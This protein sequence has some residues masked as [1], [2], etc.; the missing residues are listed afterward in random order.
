M[1]DPTIYALKVD[2]SWANVVFNSLR[3][4]VGKFGWS[5][6]RDDKGRELSSADLQTLKAKIEALGWNNLTADEAD[7]YQSFLL[8][9]RPGDWVVY[10]NVP[11]WGLCTVARVTAP[12]F[13][14]GKGED[15]NH[16][17]GVDPNSVQDFDRNH[18]IVHPALSARLKLQGR[19]WRIYA[20]KEFD[21]LWAALR[22][23]TTS[24]PRTP[25]TNAILLGHEM[26]PLLKQITE[27]VQRTHP[28]Y[29]LEALLELVFKV[30]PGVRSVIRQGGAGD[31]GADLIV[32][33]EGGLPH[34]ALQVQQKWVVQAKSYVG[35]HWDTRAVKDISRAFDRHPDADFGLIVS[36][37]ASSSP[38]LDQA[39]S[40][41]EKTSGK[42]VR[43]MIGSELAKFIL[44][45]GTSVLA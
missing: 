40:Q 30:V 35:E 11:Q 44:K 20:A 15:F 18:D 12:Y 6:M 31:H 10:I 19:K 14:D 43:L 2:Q 37:A 7:R 33:F 9:L 1:P 16:C 32:E 8:D 28:N 24:Q 42:H 21:R 36:T 3:Q 23:G 13:W 29:D 45:F 25:L 41:L 5:Y 27:V 17:F 26:E 22:S 4:G 34:P 38:T 39:I